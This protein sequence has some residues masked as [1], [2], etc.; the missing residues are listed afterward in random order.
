MGVFV[1]NS[2][3]QKNKEL[4]C[5]FYLRIVFTKYCHHRKWFGWA[6]QRNRSCKAF[7]KNH[8][9]FLVWNALRALSRKQ[10]QNLIHN[11]MFSFYSSF[12]GCVYLLY[13]QGYGSGKRLT[14][15]Y[16]KLIGFGFIFEQSKC[17]FCWLK[18]SKR[19]PFKFRELSNWVIFL[20]MNFPWMYRKAIFSQVYIYLVWV[21][22][23]FSVF[24]FFHQQ[25][26]LAKTIRFLRNEF[27][28]TKCTLCEQ[29]EPYW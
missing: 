15:S 11:C 18:T 14:H 8:S 20:E 25:T 12:L 4:R 23:V 16:R 6:A 5:N 22:S 10:Q 17:Y 27:D 19:I 29:F 26:E 28:L 1:Y 21:I 7:Q 24:K 9:L 3:V 13:C 2:Y